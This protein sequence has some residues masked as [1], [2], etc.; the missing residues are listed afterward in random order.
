MEDLYQERDD[1]EFD[2]SLAVW[3]ADSRS[4]LLISSC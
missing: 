4:A 2:L 3:E 1:M